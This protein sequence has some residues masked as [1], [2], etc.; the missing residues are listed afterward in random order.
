MSK[1]DY[2]FITIGIVII[3]ILG[4]I[5]G[6]TFNN[7]ESIENTEVK[8]KAGQIEKK[9]EPILEN[10]EEVPKKEEKN[11]SNTDNNVKTKK[12]EINNNNLNETKN[13]KQ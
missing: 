1:K 9:E 3:L 8:D 6:M 4:I 11:E 5:L 2:I 10:V 12:E 13:K 7:D